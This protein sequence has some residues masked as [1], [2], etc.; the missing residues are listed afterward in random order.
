MHT[1]IHQRFSVPFQ[2]PVHF[3]QNLFD[4]ENRLFS[5]LVRSR[6]TPKVFFVI[7][8]GVA[9]AWPNLISDIRH[10]AIRHRNAF[11]LCAEPLVVPGGEAAKNNRQCLETILQATERHAIDRHSYLVAIGGGAVLDMAGFA[12]AIAHRGIRHIRIPTTVLAQNDSGVGVK[13]GINAYGKKNY[14]GT[15]APPCA[16]IN[17]AAFLQTLDG[18]DW[19]AGMAEAVKVA[20]IKDADFFQWMEENAVRLATRQM[21]PMQQLIHRCAELH[22]QHIA[23][24]DPFECGSSRPL[25][26]G[27]WSAH[28]LEQLTD[29]QLR[30]GEAVAIG[31]ALDATYSYLSGR[32]SNLTL[33]R[34][35]TLIKTLGFEVY[36]PEL[37]G[38]AVLK[39]LEEFREHLGGRLTL[40]LLQEIGQGVEVHA[41]DKTLILRAINKL[42]RFEAAP[43]FGVLPQI[44]YHA[45]QAGAAA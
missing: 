29:Y 5:D 15:F 41:M 6:H 37:E 9:G 43:N 10:Y 22:L 40:M 30:H 16:V 23:G 3:T 24:V 34:I 11:S 33:E 32:I 31:I 42:K 35:V 28:K 36:V 21:E 1:T 8:E 19:R 2:Y 38:S 45:I 7:D 13:N 39:G 20:L 18:R 12:A 25:D 14:L 27:H 44:P 4:G 26:F 17:D